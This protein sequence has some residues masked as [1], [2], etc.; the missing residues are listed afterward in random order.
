MTVD[1]AF[2][3]GT[4]VLVIATDALRPRHTAARR[5]I[6]KA[7][8]RGVYL[9]LSGQILREYLSVATRPPGSNGLGLSST[10]VV[11]NTDRFLEFASLVEEK[12]SVAQRLRG[13]VATRNVRGKQVHDAGIVAT[14][15]VHHIPCLITENARDFERFREIRTVSI[16]QLTERLA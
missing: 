15:L 16:Q 9:V 3:V 2:F 13:L 6:E 14:M 4:N 8:S 12:A 7:V 5:L 1:E 11:Q 10:T